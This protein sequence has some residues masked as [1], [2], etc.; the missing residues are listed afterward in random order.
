MSATV[1]AG[2]RHTETNTRA[3]AREWAMFCL[4]GL[5]WGSSFLWIKV[6]LGDSTS[7]GFA[8]L[9]LV[10]FRLLFGLGGLLVLLAARGVRLPREWPT[11]RAC[12]VVGLFNTA[13]PFTLI[14]WGETRIASGMAAILNGTVPLFTIVIAHFSLH[15]EPITPARAAGLV[16]G[17]AGVVVLVSRGL[18]SAL[19]SVWGQLAVVAAALSYAGAAAYTRRSLRN[20]SPLAQSTTTLLFATVYMAAAVLVFERP[21]ALPSRPLAWLAAAWLGLLGSCLA[22]VLYFSLINAWGATRATLVTYVFPLVGLVLGIVV[23]GEP[24]D[25]RLLAGTA[26]IVGGIIVVNARVFALGSRAVSK[27]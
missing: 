13:L 15:D 16:A 9:L 18:G 3:K 12:A 1:S 21:A 19:G 6:A 14:T 2:S 7:P 22:Y 17:F 8:P 25:W 20:L 26:M 27:N 5:I 24:T 11:L 10:S 4:L 23:L